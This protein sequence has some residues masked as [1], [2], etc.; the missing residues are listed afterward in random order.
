MIVTRDAS[1]GDWKTASVHPDR[2]PTLKAGTE[3]EFINEWENFYGRW[4]R[5]R[6]PNGSEYDIEP[7]RLRDADDGPVVELVRER[8]AYD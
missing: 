1:H 7:N 8:E 2:W 6:G 4:V 3:V 5:V